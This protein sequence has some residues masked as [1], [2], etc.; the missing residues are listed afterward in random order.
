M[1]QQITQYLKR[2]NITQRFY[3]GFATMLGALLVMGIIYSISF[4]HNRY[5]FNDQITQA[6]VLKT[7]L[8]EITQ[9]NT[10]TIQNFEILQQQAS[11]VGVLYEDLANLRNIRNEIASLNFKPSQQRKLDRLVGELLAW[12]NTQA[13]KHPFIAPYAG[14]FTILSELLRTNPS[15]DVVRDIGLVI[16]DITGKITEETLAF[17][18]KTQETMGSVKA[19]LTQ[20]NTNLST[21][22]ET[23]HQTVQ[24]LMGLGETNYTHAIYLLIASIVFAL[25]LAFM[26]LMVK[27][28]VTDTRKMRTYFQQVIHDDQHIDLRGRMVIDAQS[29]DEMDCIGKVIGTVFQSV[30]RTILE[31]SNIGYG[32]QHAAKSLQKTSQTL[33]G[34]ILAQESSIDTMREPIAKL[35]QTLTNAQGMSEQTRDAL[36]QNISVM[37]QF[38]QG[39]ETLHQNVQQSKEEQIDVNSHMQEL[40]TQVQEMKSVLNII[41]DIADQTNLLA[42][43]AA[44]EAARA[45]EYGK[46][47]SVVADEVRKLAEKTQNSLGNIDVIV[48]QMVESVRK[49]STKLGHVTLLMDTTA[50]HMNDLG[51][52]ANKTKKEVTHSL[53]IADKS[54][55]LAKMVGESVNTLIS[56]MQ[57][58][59]SLSVTNRG[60]AQ[61]VSGVSQE[62]F[63]ISHTLTETLSKFVHQ[64]TQ[65]LE[66]TAPIPLTFVA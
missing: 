54:V 41:D 24:S 43:N 19:N 39:I 34:T 25:T 65:R 44:I 42:L 62:L 3:L 21:Q 55:E 59:L 1:S 12:Q 61:A 11:K 40:F 56:Q 8:S 29:K 38:I 49:N 17:S 46:G 27:L 52:L 26:A 36:R 9:V 15:E 63:S 4:F 13:G 28:I 23:L 18:T 50:L 45:G 10:K 20:L 58:S 35:K 6:Q 2:M 37:E 31:V 5:F 57:E 30:E 22:G 66:R 51:S 64:E 16:E 48:K 47:F 32:A 14:Q 33:M 7:N 60:N 53:H